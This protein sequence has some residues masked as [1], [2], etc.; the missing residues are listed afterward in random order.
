MDHRRAVS[1]G[2]RL[3]AEPPLALVSGPASQI[4]K[5]A[6]VTTER[7]I[8]TGRTETFVQ[9]AG[10]IADSPLVRIISPLTTQITVPVLAEVGPEP[11]TDTSGTTGTTETTSTQ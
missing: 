9:S 11:P 8:M 1:L 7:I 5:L 3:A 2:R 10:V 6:E 4:M